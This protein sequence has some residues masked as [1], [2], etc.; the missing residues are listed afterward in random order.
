MGTWGFTTMEQGS[1]DWMENY[2]EKTSRAV[3]I[4]AKSTYQYYF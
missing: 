3:D 2:Q 4:Q 1:S